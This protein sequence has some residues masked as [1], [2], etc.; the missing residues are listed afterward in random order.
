MKTRPTILTAGAACAACILL[1]PLLLAGCSSETPAPSNPQTPQTPDETP[2]KPPARGSGTNP[3]SLPPEAF[4]PPPAPEPLTGGNQAEKLIAQYEAKL[5]TLEGDDR[6]GALTAMANLYGRKL[7]DY[8]NA[9]K[10]YDLVIHEFPDMSG[11]GN[12]YAELAKCYEQLG[13][14]AKLNQLYLDMMEH[15]P[16]D[17]QEHLFAKQGLGL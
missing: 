12:Y 6:F 15:F 4:N 8:K 16:E 1:I 9:A 3:I 10:Y 7:R 17:S 2:A 14:Q 11:I 13:D 5:P